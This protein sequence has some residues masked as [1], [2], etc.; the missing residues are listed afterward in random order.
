MGDNA[1][2]SDLAMTRRAI[3]EGW[4]VPEEAKAQAGPMAW[5]IAKRTYKKKPGTALKALRTLLE[6]EQA[7]KEAPKTGQV[8]VIVHNE[9]RLPDSRPAADAPSGPETGHP[10]FQAV[11]R[12]DVRKTLGE[13]DAG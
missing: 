11:Q 3:R 7:Q 4:D 12:F 13:D 6:I 10:R 1:R 8:M 2:A 9:N 5:A